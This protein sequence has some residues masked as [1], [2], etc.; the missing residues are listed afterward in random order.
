MPEIHLRPAEAADLPALVALEHEYLT[1]S[2]WQMDVLP[3][4]EGQMQLAFR[5]QRLPHPTRVECPRRPERL[6]EDWQQRPGLLVATAAEKTVGYISL[7]FS[8]AQAKAAWVTDLVVLQALRRQGIGSALTLAAL[9]WAYVH[10]CEQLVL[11]MQPKNTPAIQLAQK[12]GFAFSGYQDHYYA[13]QD[14][15]LFFV[16]NVR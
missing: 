13:N 6:L 10:R 5:P 14:L 3:T 12:L 15:A 9:E 4:E 2:V 16:R 11:E 8:L 7:A 1:E